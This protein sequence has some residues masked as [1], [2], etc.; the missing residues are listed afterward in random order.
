[1]DVSG[2]VGETKLNNDKLEKIISYYRD[3][4][5]DIIR[6]SDLLELYHQNKMM[7]RLKLLNHKE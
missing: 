7:E 5:N 1:M 6:A 2:N 4:T 3:G